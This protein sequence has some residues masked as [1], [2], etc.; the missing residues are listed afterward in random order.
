MNSEDFVDFVYPDAALRDPLACLRH[1]IMA[2]MNKQVDEYNLIP[3]Q[4]LQGV[5]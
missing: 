2:P 4:R 1:G 3:L 5:H